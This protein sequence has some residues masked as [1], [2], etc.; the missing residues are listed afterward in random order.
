MK[1]EK[2]FNG[3]IGF[4]PVSLIIDLEK[5]KKY[6][7]TNLSLY[8]KSIRDEEVKDLIFQG[9]IIKNIEFLKW[10]TGRLLADGHYI[11]FILD[12]PELSLINPNDLIT[13]R[14]ILLINDKILLDKQT[15]HIKKLSDRD[16]VIVQTN[17]IAELIYIQSVLLT[18]EFIGSMYVDIQDIP[19]EKLLKAGIYNTYPYERNG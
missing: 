14:I 10:L 9:E 12:L 1:T 17:K 6:H 19:K 15:S 18:N 5:N 13:H 11:S 2:K 8:H 16:I 3:Y 7:V 4:D